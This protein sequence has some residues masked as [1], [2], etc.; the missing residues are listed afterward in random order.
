MLIQ[1]QITMDN[2]YIYILRQLYHRTDDGKGDSP[3]EFLLMYRSG[4]KDNDAIMEQYKCLRL[5]AGIIV[6]QTEHGR[7]PEGR[8]MKRS[9]EVTFNVRISAGGISGKLS[10][11]SYQLGR[12]KG[13]WQDERLEYLDMKLIR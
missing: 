7:A 9:S 2:M 13:P 6:K 10:K 4:D 11:A 3:S 5:E 12:R 8:S 1:L